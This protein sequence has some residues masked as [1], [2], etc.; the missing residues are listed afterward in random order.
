[1]RHGSGEQQLTLTNLIPGQ[2]YLFSYF[3]QAWNY[4]VQRNRTLACSAHLQNLTF[5]QN[6]YVSDSQDGILV[7]CFY[8]ATSKEVTFS[9]NNS[10]LY[11]FSN[12][13][14]DN[15]N[16]LFSMDDNG[17]LRTA[18]ALDFE[19]A[20]TR[21]LTVQVFDEFNASLDGNF[22][23]S[24]E[25]IVE[26]LDGDSI[27]DAFDEDIDGDGV[28]NLDEEA[29]GS[30]PL[31]PS[32]VNRNPNSL[33]TSGSLSV[34]ENLPL[35]SVIGSFTASDP[36]SGDSLSYSV[37]PLQPSNLTPSLWLD[38]S[39]SDTLA[40]FDGKVQ[41]STNYFNKFQD[42][43]NCSNSVSYLNTII[44]VFNQVRSK[45]DQKPIKFN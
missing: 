21:N 11:A 10:H 37:V 45:N 39:D 3:A 12:R 43:D 23:L 27:E 7:E 13:E 31:D 5:N 9:F 40:T 19:R 8:L 6:A 22:T 15:D 32:S 4:E 33:S 20:S 28:S 35:N 17:T 34:P 16:Y 25:N 38:A 30:D 18:Y 29:Q 44:L 42:S 36:D 2:V 24:V 26:D 1:M 14:L 41:N